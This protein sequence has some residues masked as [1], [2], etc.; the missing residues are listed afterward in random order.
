VPDLGQVAQAAPQLLD[1]SVGQISGPID[2]QRTGVV[3]KLVDKQE[4][5]A[6]EMAKDFDQ[7][8]EQIKDQRQSEAFSV[9]LSGAVQ[10]YNKHGRIRVNAKAQ[11]PEIPGA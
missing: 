4:P 9:F 8:R 7:M 11:V 5:T 2:G 6:E 1:L 10:D 3:A